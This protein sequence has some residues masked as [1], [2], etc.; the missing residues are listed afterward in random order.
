MVKIIIREYG[1]VERMVRIIVKRV[2]RRVMERMVNI[3]IRECRR[4]VG[5]Y[6]YI[7][8]EVVTMFNCK[9]IFDN[10]IL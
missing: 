7:T 5:R 2:S 4:V 1:E 8:I 10:V 3:I 9:L 6:D